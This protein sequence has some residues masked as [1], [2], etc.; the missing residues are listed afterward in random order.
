MIAVFRKTEQSQ[1]VL[2]QADAN[3]FV[4]QRQTIKMFVVMNR[5]CGS[6]NNTET[7]GRPSQ[8]GIQDNMDEDCVTGNIQVVLLTQGY[9]CFTFVK[10]NINYIN[11]YTAVEKNDILFQIS[12]SRC[13]V[14]NVMLQMLLSL[15]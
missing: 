4:S 10:I 8:T 11:I 1:F 5:G 6:E 13:N 2:P 3:R 14:T 9:Q 15:L 7:S 12:I